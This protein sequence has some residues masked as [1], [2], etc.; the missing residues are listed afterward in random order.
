MNLLVIIMVL[1]ARNNCIPYMNRRR[2]GYSALPNKD[3]VIMAEVV[4]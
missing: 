3:D 1:A 4:I 2:Q